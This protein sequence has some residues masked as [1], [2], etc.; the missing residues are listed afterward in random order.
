MK[1]R[2]ETFEVS[3]SR[4]FP[5]LQGRRVEDL[6]RERECSPLDVMCELSVSEDLTT[7]FRGVHRQRRRR[8]RRRAAHP[9]P[10]RARSLRRGCAR[11]PAVRRAA[12][13]RPARCVGARARRHAA[14]TRGPQAERRAGR[15]VRLRRAAATSARATTPTCACSTRKP[16]A[17]DRSGASATSPPNGERLT[18]EEPAGVRHVLVNGTPIR[19]DGVQIESLQALPGTQPEIA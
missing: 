18:A 13:H 12:A 17:P 6:A 10:R 16:W 1:P 4:R 2:W 8:R 15:H 3:E 19:T 14:R 9:R 5:E 7:R 11:R